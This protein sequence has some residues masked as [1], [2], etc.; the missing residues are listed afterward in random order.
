MRILKLAQSYPSTGVGQEGHVRN[1]SIDLA[2]GVNDVAKTG[3]PR[4]KTGQSE[5]G[6][7]SERR[8]PTISVI[9]CAYT[10]DRW[11]L[12]LRSVASAQE[13][14]LQPCEIIVCV[15]QPLFRRCAAQW[16]DFAASTPPIR[17]IQNKWDG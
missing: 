6:V 1:P 14:T 13:Q 9:I 17:V 11:A 4:S 5:D 8:P 16:A 10:A 15:D 2:R 3:Q 12:L 7:S